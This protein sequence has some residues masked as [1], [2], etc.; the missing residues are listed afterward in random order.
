MLLLVVFRLV[1]LRV[2]DN[3]DADA[4]VSSTVVLFA[5]FAT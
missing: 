5:G 2:D 3:D 1:L 4:T